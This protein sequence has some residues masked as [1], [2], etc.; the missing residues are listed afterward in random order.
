MNDGIKELNIDV[1]MTEWENFIV[2]LSGSGR[3]DE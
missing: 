3:S 1:Q 2:E